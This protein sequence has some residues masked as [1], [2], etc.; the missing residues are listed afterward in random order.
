MAL[1]PVYSGSGVF[2]YGDIR[3][4]LAPPKSPLF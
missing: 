1:D 4:P 3:I 2:F